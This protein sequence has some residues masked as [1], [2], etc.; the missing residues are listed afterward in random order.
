M[1]K[2][3]NTYKSQRETMH[4]Y[5]GKT[6]R[7]TANFSSETMEDRGGDIKILQVLNEKNCQSRILYPAEISFRNKGEIKTF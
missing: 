7:M 4:H 3:L 6:I 2:L 5:K 1:V